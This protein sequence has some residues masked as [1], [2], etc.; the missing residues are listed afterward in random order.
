MAT[1]SQRS[2]SAVPEGKS[3]ISFEEAMNELSRDE[4]FKATVYAMNTLLVEKGIYSPEEF[5]FHF[6]Q[7]AQKLKK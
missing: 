3:L 2:Y 1:A 4:R 6:R 7:W 5:E